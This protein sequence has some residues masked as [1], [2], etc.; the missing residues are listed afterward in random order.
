MVSIISFIIIGIATIS[1]FIN[2]FER[3]NTD[4]LS[5]TMRIMVNEMQKRL[6][7]HRTFDDVVKIYDSVSNSDIQGLV[8][9]VSEIHNVDVNIYDLRVICMFPHSR[10]CT[11]KDF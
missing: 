3:N 7:D 5:R 4:K 10:W 6:I 2:R 8:E 9:E 1:F 11:R